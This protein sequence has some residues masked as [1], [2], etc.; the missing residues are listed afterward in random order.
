MSNPLK[1]GII[2][3]IIMHSILFG[4]EPYFLSNLKSVLRWLL[5]AF[6]RISFFVGY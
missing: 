1:V 2:V 4:W 5:V 6:T 3:Q